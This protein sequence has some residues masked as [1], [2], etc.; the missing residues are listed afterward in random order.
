MFNLKGKNAVITGASNGI[1]KAIALAFAE[2][3]ANTLLTYRSDESAIL[4][5][6]RQAQK[7]DTVCEVVQYDAASPL[8]PLLDKVN[9]TFGQV[10]ILVNNIGITTRTNF[11]EIS[12]E[13]YDQ[14]FDA[15]IKAP[16]FLTQAIARQMVLNEVQGSLI[17]VS[18][19]SS[20]KAISEMTHYQSSKAALTMMSNSI[21]LELACYGIRS[22]VISPGLTATKGNQNQWQD[23]PVLWQER[24]KDI[25]LRRAGVPQDHAGAAV[26]L[27]SENSSWITGANIV[28]DGGEA[29]I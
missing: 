18:S 23:D 2:Q 1:G 22:N 20:F 19:I 21:A 6:Q 4:E 5:V 16:F 28:I 13:E 29:V 24:G 17:H 12:D 25:P 11:L 26:F 14:V 27:A 15:N 7:Y 3:G 10:D 9:Q 8:P